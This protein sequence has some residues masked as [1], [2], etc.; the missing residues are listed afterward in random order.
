MNNWHAFDTPQHLSAALAE[1]LATHLQRA[2]EEQGHA[3]LAVSGGKSPIPLFETLARKPIHWGAIT[4]TLVDERWVGSDHPDSNEKQVRDHLLQHRAADAAF[5]GLKN[6]ADD[7]TAG[8][9]ACE[10]QLSALPTRL[11]AVVLGMGTDGHTASWFADAAEYSHAVDADTTERVCAIH[12]Q[13]APHPRLTLT[14]PAVLDSDFIAL[15]ISGAEKRQVFESAV[16]QQLP[17]A[18]LLR[19]TQTPL[20]IY[21]S[22]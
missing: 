4:I 11:T 10:R 15:M 21:W 13:H 20:N 3:S 19:Q 22:P 17:V 8:A 2:V 9:A 6:R 16:K 18:H 14:L 12:P 7:A 5:I 1:Q